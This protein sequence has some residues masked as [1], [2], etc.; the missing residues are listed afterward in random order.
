MTTTYQEQWLTKAPGRATDRDNDN[1]YDCVDVPKDYVE[2]IFA[3]TSWRDVWPQA[4]NAKDML[5][6]ANTEY[7]DIIANDAGNPD[8]IPQRGDIIV[9]GGNGV[10]PYGHI[11]VVVGAD[12]N[13]VDVIQ[14]DT[15]Q[16]TP[17]SLG[18]LA[19]DNYGTGPCIGWLR[20]K[21]DA[22]APAPAPA[23]ATGPATRTVTNDVGWARVSPWSSA[24]PAPAY[25]EGIAKGSQ[26]SV[27]GYVKGEDP[28]GAG[29][30]AWYKTISGLYMWANAAGNDVS[31]LTFLGDMSGQVPAPTPQPAPAP[32]PVVEKYDFALDFA[33]L[34]REDGV[35][36]SIVKSPADIGNLQKGNPSAKYANAVIHQFGTPDVD[37]FASTDSQ[38]KKPGTLVSA[39]WSVSGR[40]VH[41]HV[42]LAD[43]AYH[44]ATVGNDY[45][46]IETDP[47]Q[48]AETIA[49]VRALL[50]ALRKQGKATTLWLHR[51][52]PG[53]STNCGA[54]ID[55][56]KYDL[57]PKPTPAPLDS[58][59]AEEQRELLRLVRYVASAQFRADLF[60]FEVPWHGFDGNVPA[61]GR[62][63]TTLGTDLGWA[64]A[65]AAGLPSA[66]AAELAKKLAA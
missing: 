13:G 3:S 52:V 61:S 51:D 55:L 5:W 57:T 21:F 10:N 47:H 29:D 66:T 64:D 26:I 31:G 32:T 39:H 28:Y 1:S 34:T 43:R 18:H 9:Y 4:G 33:S 63:T 62:T 25:P 44:A 11:A 40:N 37:T 7:V 16:Q 36:I 20:P 60:N 14:E 50:I 45:I 49:T 22:P 56:A 23:P 38:F 17:M 12:V 48:D 59:T 6:P 53:C 30:D 65:R 2:A 24:D 35:V 41:Q 8:L 27:V 42:A 46:G 54:L 15:F 19:Y 58:L